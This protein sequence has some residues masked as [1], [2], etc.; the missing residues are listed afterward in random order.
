MKIL[1]IVLL[2]LFSFN[3]YAMRCGQGLINVGDRVDQL[4][5]V[6]GQPAAVIGKDIYGDHAVAIYHQEGGMTA[7]VD[8]RDGVIDDIQFHRD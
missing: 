1:L 7:I 8:I 6:C 4:Y 5:T 2:A 3:S